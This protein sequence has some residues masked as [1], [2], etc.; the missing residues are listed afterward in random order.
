MRSL[1]L[2]V[3]SAVLLLLYVQ[4]VGSAAAAKVLQ[5]SMFHLQPLL[6]RGRICI[7][8]SY[9]ALEATADVKHQHWNKCLAVRS[10]SQ[11]CDHLHKWAHTTG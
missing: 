1:V 4:E 8:L 9:I 10:A 7:R 5:R 6:Q 11:C 3:H 2:C